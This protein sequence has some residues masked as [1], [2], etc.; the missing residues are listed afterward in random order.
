MD[1]AHCIM[2]KL[3][4]DM[5]IMYQAR[6]YLDKKASLICIICMFIHTNLLRGIWG[7]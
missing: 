6:T 5:G 3:S 4:I 2:S 7:Q 1:P